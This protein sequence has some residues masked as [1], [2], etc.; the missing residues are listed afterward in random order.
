MM[1]FKQIEIKPELNWFKRNLWSQHVKRSIIFIVTGAIIGFLYF[2]ITE[3]KNMDIIT[4]GDIFKSVLFG[5]FM[6]FFLTNSPCARN[7]C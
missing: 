7:K 6:G 3:G 1:E 4:F 2:Y 5:A